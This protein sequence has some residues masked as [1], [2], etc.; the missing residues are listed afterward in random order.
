MLKKTSTHRTHGASYNILANE[1]SWYEL[2]GY[3]ADSEPLPLRAPFGLMN[4]K[5]GQR[6]DVWFGE[7]LQVC[8]HIC[9][10]VIRFVHT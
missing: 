1:G 2:E 3:N 9:V 5:Q 10:R 4:I 7:D 6:F 8:V